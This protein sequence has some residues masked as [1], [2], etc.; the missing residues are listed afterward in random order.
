MSSQKRSSA[1]A[2]PDAPDN[3]EWR[4]ERIGRVR[5]LSVVRSRWGYS[6]E[7]RD[8]AMTERGARRNVRRA[9]RYIKERYQ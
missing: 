5:W 2:W 3:V 6:V 8:A 4:I 1:T 7:Q 9:A